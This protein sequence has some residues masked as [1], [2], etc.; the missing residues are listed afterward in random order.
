M[1]K[2]VQK[3][4][5]GAEAVCRFNIKNAAREEKE[6]SDEKVTNTSGISTVSGDG[7]WRKRGFSSLFGFVSLIGWFTGKVVD[8]LVKSKY[9]K[10]RSDTDEY[11]EWAKTHEDECQAN[12]EGSAGKMEVDVV[13]EMFQRSESLHELKYENYVGDGDSKT[14]KAILNSQPY[15][16]S[17]CI[18]GFTQNSNENFNATV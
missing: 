7:S 4:A 5:I 8:V 15:G 3:I 17:R 18:G 11:K 13:I 6:K 10:K 2:V 1:T 16:N 9:W 12:H 14:F